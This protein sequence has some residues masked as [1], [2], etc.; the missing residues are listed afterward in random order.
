MLIL[1]SFL[2]KFDID[3]LV[4]KYEKQ[5]EYI[6]EFAKF[7][8]AFEYISARF[9]EIDEETIWITEIFIM[10]AQ[11]V[12]KN[13]DTQQETALSAKY[14][15]ICDTYFE[16]LEGI[17]HSNFLSKLL[18]KLKGFSDHERDSYRT[19]LKKV[20]EIYYFFIS[21]KPEMTQQ[22]FR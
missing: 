8:D 5:T 21:N 19:I 9:E 22:L 13:L 4:I 7:A 17:D 20:L 1:Q 11:I 15:K 14:T 16:Y 6:E 18:K 2:N 3:K 10:C 12:K